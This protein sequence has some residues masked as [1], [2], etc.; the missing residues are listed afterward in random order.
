MP[1]SL[2]MDLGV[3]SSEFSRFIAGIYSILL[4]HNLTGKVEDLNIMIR[5]ISTGY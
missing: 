3:L 5:N 1:N 2:L 4:F